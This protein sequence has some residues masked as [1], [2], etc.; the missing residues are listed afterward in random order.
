[1]RQVE[2]NYK[3]KLCF[4]ANK[5]IREFSFRVKKFRYK[6]PPEKVVK[7]KELGKSIMIVKIERTIFGILS[8]ITFIA[9]FLFSNQNGEESS[10]TSGK[11]VRAIINITPITRNID[12]IRKEEIIENSQFIVRKLAH[13]TI[14]FI[15]GVNV[16]GF[17]N[18]F[19][20][21]NSK[22]IILIALS[23]CVL[24][25]ILDEIHQY[26]SRR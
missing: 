10:S 17:I 24:Y 21:L 26:A 2:Y 22:Q 19:N 9:I 1:M 4:R 11:F 7:F 6:R 16:A 12:K 3:I 8:I 23:L 14:Y 20:K 13:F 25:A 15:L 5:F 18:T